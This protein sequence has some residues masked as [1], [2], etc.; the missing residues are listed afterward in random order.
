[1]HL[2]LSKKEIIILDI[3]SN[4]KPKDIMLSGEPYLIDYMESIDQTLSCFNKT[5]LI[6]DHLHMWKYNKFY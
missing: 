6:E 4:Y 3:A 2:E 1:M 5:I